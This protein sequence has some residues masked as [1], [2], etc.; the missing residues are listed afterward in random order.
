[1]KKAPQKLFICVAV[2]KADMGEKEGIGKIPWSL[3]EICFTR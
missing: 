1:L 2:E 3:A